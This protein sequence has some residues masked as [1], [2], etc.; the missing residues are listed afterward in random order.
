MQDNRQLLGK[1]ASPFVV[2]INH[3]GQQSVGRLQGLIALLVSHSPILSFKIGVRLVR[4]GSFPSWDGCVLFKSQG[5][6]SRGR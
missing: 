3:P 2:N 4:F 5:F 6:C 1:V